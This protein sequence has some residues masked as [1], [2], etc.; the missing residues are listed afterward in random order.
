MYEYNTVIEANDSNQVKEL[1]RK[2][3]SLQA[4]LDVQKERTASM[5]G[6]CLLRSEGIDYY[7]GEQL[8]FVL[9]ILEQVKDRCPQGSRPYDIISS[10]LSVNKPVGRGREILDELNRIFNKG[11][12]SSE[13]D[14]SDLKSIGFTYV[15]SRKH[16][17]L[18][19][20]DK[21]MFILPCTTSDKHHS[22]K[23]SLSE[24]NKCIAL[25]QRV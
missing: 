24:I 23:N 21:Y 8:D 22:A 7:P 17:K 4:Q 12:P 9:S 20:Q 13:S 10:L 16:P 3:I 18:R 6:G 2:I 11:M 15:Q 14:I 5:K 25:S 19:Y 1:K